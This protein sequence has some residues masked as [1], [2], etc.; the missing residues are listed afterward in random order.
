MKIRDCFDLNPSRNTNKYTDYINYIDTSSVNEGALDDVT[1]LEEDFPS[2]AQRL[3]KKGD[4][5]YSSVRPNLRH[6]CLYRD[7]Y[8]HVVAST[9][10]VLLRH[11]KDNKMNPEFLYYYLTTNEVVKYLSGIAEISQATFPSFSSK[12]IGGIDIPEIDR[13]KQDRIVEVIS[14][15][16]EQIEYNTKRIRI[17]EDMMEN[18]YKEWFVRMRYP[19]S[20]G[21][22]NSKELPEGWERKHISD[23]YDT[24][25][26]GTPSRKN[27]AFYEDGTIP[28]IK[29]G[30]MQ[31]CLLIK[32]EECI[33]EEAVKRSSAKKIPANSV[34]MA[35]YGV[36]IGKLA[37]TTME[38]TCN[39]AC[40]VFSDKY[41]ESSKHYLFQYLK[42]IREYLLL[43][44]FGAAQQ[45]LSQDLIKK[46]KMVMPEKSVV[47]AFEDVIEPLYLENKNLLYATENLKRQ[48]EMIIPRLMSGKIVI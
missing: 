23:Y 12:D 3:V 44:G 15:Y 8:E 25:S 7:D 22:H 40:C 28:W 42:S 10:F 4:I 14:T 1:F 21:S 35:M 32:T 26:G 41:Y 48:R 33:T 37:Y 18:I 27:D 20:D 5:L 46:V 47:K 2:R 30:E 24:S 45:N 17:L 16:N 34:M 9:G 36:N 13:D 11:K 43:I 38:A 6:Y 31:D 19:G 29:T 39:Q